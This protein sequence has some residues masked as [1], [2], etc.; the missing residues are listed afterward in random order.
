M[1]Y[2]YHWEVDL[3]LLGLSMLLL[4][5]FCIQSSYELK[6]WWADVLMSWRVDVLWPLPLCS[7][8]RLASSKI[9][10]STWIPWQIPSC[11][12][13]RLFH[14]HTYFVWDLMWPEVN[15]FHTASSNLWW[16]LQVQASILQI[17]VPTSNGLWSLIQWNVIGS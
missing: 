15:L 8:P 2:L 3:Q 4:E 5:T 12:L 11:L 6:V 16:Y 13:P 14:Q 9:E 10:C 17:A 1:N 7:S